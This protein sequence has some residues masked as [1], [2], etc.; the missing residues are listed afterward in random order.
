MVFHAPPPRP[1]LLF[2]VFVFSLLPASS[3]APGLVLT[4][5]SKTLRLAAAP[6]E[7]TLRRGPHRHAKRSP[8]LRVVGCGTPFAARSASASEVASHPDAAQNV[9]K[10]VASEDLVHRTVNSE[11]VRPP[12]NLTETEDTGRRPYASER[13]NLHRA[14]L[15]MCVRGKDVVSVDQWRRRSLTALT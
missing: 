6:R 7:Q 11:Q 9:S 3:E 15:S 14:T 12:S 13:K 10:D 2:S 1:P 5:R 8:Q 4:E